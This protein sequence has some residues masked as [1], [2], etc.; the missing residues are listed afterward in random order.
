MYTWTNFF[1]KKH[2][3]SLVIISHFLR[4]NIINPIQSQD[5]RFPNSR[6]PRSIPWSAHHNRT[7]ISLGDLLPAALHDPCCM[8]RNSDKSLEGR[9][10]SH[11]NPWIPQY[12][13]WH[14]VKFKALVLCWGNFGP[15]KNYSC[16]HGGRWGRG[17]TMHRPA[18]Q[19]RATHRVPRALGMRNPGFN[20]FYGKNWCY[21]FPT[22]GGF[23]T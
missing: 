19:Q 21:S 8:T 11:S 5:G 23:R 22:P 2:M 3:A 20:L 6:L 15:R 4:E 9:S 17:C 18:L 16:F 10:L 7:P 12:L 1:L 14:T 13:A